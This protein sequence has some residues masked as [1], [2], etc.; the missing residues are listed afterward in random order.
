MIQQIKS[1]IGSIFTGVLYIIIAYLL[2]FE[3]NPK[4]ANII[5]LLCSFSLNFLIQSYIYT[6]K[7]LTTTHI[8]K[9]IIVIIVYT[10]INQFILSYFINNKDKIIKYFPSIIQPHYTTIIRT[11][12]LIFMYIGISNPL[13]KYWVFI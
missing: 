2:D 12:L 8:Y 3:L 7:K 13:R 6:K 4:V 5:G 10:L 11:C 1:I 9:E